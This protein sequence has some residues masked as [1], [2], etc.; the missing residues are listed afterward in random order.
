MI[1]NEELVREF[2]VESAEHLAAIES[3]LLEIESAGANLNRDLVNTVFRNVHSIKGAASFFGLNSISELSHHLENIL[4]RMREGKLIPKR[5]NVEPML[6]AADLL[7][8]MIDDVGNSNQVDPTVICQELDLAA[9]DQAPAFSEPA[10]PTLSAPAVTV[11]QEVP[12]AAAQVSAPQPSPIPTPPPMQTSQPVRNESVEEHPERHDP[13]EAHQR[14]QE[15][16]K[17]HPADSAKPAGESSIR[18]TVEVL[19]Q[20][21]NLAGEMVLGR[22]QLMQSVYSSER[23]GLESVAARI[24]QITSELQDAIMRTRMQPIGNVFTRFT[25][26]VRDLSQK[27]GK[28]C[29]L[30]IEGKDV[31]VDKTIIEAI[32]DPLTHLIRNAV[33]HGLEM[34][35]G[36]QKSGKT[37]CGTIHLKAYHQSGRV[38]I[39]I[40]DDG[41]GMDPQALKSKAVE[42]GLLSADDARDM[43]DADAYR[44]IFLPGFSTAEKL[45]DISGRAWVWMW[46][47]PTLKSWAAPS[48]SNRCWK[49]ARRF[50]SACL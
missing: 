32:G 4:N 5:S 15:Q 24:N 21:M 34:P 7:R 36:R 41:K 9:A 27:L 18:V 10:A 40:Q 29:Q 16:P 12:T 46:S 49:W 2:V 23:V 22:N 35:A 28:Q 33:D 37:P 11:A 3:Q 14:Q 38:R 17:A 19:D 25:R 13:V 39:D 47:V 44:L 50:M 30:V 48:K 20:L 6:R 45:S 8:S 26:I 43:S 31:E 1:E 42:K